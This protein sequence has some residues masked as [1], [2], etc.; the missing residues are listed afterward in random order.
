MVSMFCTLREAAQQ[1]Q[2]SE[3]QVEA[4]LRDGLLRE[5]RE[6]ACRLV[7]STDVATL[8]AIRGA[9]SAGEWQPTGYEAE[10]SFASEDA[11]PEAPIVAG[12]RSAASYSEARMKLPHRAAA[13]TRAPGSRTARPRNKRQLRASTAARDLCRSRPAP[14]R[15]RV[16]GYPNRPVV[17]QVNMQAQSLSFR[18]WLWNGLIQDDPVAIALVFGLVLLVLSAL[19][20]AGCMLWSLTGSAVTIG[21]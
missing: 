9:P 16:G 3:E 18:Q 2:I 17:R 4:M 19:V 8:A 11:W 14:M 13:A 7:K 6:G 10:T 5:F 15:P 20:A 21:Q 12:P 1:L